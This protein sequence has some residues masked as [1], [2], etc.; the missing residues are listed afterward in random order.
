MQLQLQLQNTIRLFIINYNKKIK[1]TYKLKLKPIRDSF[2]LEI[3][4]SLHLKR[5][6]KNASD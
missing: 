2:Q 4:I 1:T 3:V 5:I 6:I